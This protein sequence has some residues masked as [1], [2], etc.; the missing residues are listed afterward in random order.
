M[1]FGL[2]ASFSTFVAG[3]FLVCLNASGD[4]VL[5]IAATDRDISSVPNLDASVRE[6]QC[7]CFAEWSFCA[8]I[9]V[10]LRR[11]DRAWTM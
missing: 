11:R 8:G 1:S 6:I 9:A 7:N 10:G 3:Q 5:E 2:S 4:F